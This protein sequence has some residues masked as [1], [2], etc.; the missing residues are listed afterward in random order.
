MRNLFV[1]VALTVAFSLCRPAGAADEALIPFFN[2]KDL[3]GW[4][5]VNVAPST[6]TVRDGMIVC[7]GVPTGVM[8]TEKQYENFILELEY[9]HLVPGGNA[10]LFVW[11]DAI[12]SVGVPFTRSIEVQILDG[13]ESESHTSH[14]DVFSIHGATMKPDRPHPKGAMRCLPSEKRANP[15]GQWNH[16]RVVCNDGVIKLSV[17]GKE[18]SGATEC[19]PRKG[20]ICLESE[21]GTVHYRN[22]KLAE[23]P[24]T[25]P[26][27]ADVAQADEGFRSIYT[28]V[29]L[30]GWRDEADSRAHW[31]PKDWTLVYDGKSQKRGEALW[32]EKEYGDF[33]LVA[34]WRL[35]AEPKK[36][37]RNDASG[38]PVE[39]DD[40]GDSGI[41]LRGSKKAEINIWCQPQG[42]GELTGYRGDKNAPADV[43]AAAAPTARADRKPGS[44][45]R[46]VL[47]V[48]GETCTVALNG[49]TVVENAL[50]PGVPARGPIGLQYHDSPIEFASIYVRE[51]K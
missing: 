31:Q 40:A 19:T 49:Q 21:G 27:P 35:P 12:T 11:S 26:K 18:V 5:P 33:V 30:S 10:G 38:K 14:G 3:S 51:L 1:V 41:Y 8:R 39:M 34:D 16:Y 7:T 47:T 42:S 46:F 25:N 23:L 28:G 15:A 32:T 20:Y 45:N 22:I 4:V 43:R 13:S 50:M 44:W 36:V 6:F 17:N 9:M 24:S 29:D 37:T 2:G 48:K